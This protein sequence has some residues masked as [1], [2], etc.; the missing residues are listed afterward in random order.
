MIHVHCAYLT[1]ANVFANNRGSNDGSNISPLQKVIV[2]GVR[3]STNSAETIKFALRRTMQELFPDEEYNRHFVEA[4]GTSYT[5]LEDKSGDPKRFVDDDLHGFMGTTKK[6]GKTKKGE[7]P[8]EGEAE[9]AAPGSAVIR[10]ARLEVS[11][12]IS[13]DPWLGDISFNV[14]SR[15]ENP[16]GGKPSD[17]TPY[18]AEFQHTRYQF[19]WS[20][21]PEALEVP[22]RAH[23]VFATFMQ[24]CGVGGNQ[25]SWKTDYSPD[26]VVLR[27]GHNIA[28][29][30]FGAFRPIPNNGDEVSIKKVIREVEIGD[31]NPFEIIVGGI[32]CEAD[33]DRCRALGMTVSEGIRDA[34][35][36]LSNRLIEMGVPR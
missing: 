26:A 25:A 15:S 22:S 13:I 24:L 6:V 2:N 4:D 1:K 31:I 16:S 27:I 19:G 11:R 3:H 35:A 5:T 20:I 28:P 23:K 29:G 17:P 34:F 12:A 9:P 7:K 21:T 33:G 10:R 8:A 14:R 36:D 32:V 18:Q 30:I